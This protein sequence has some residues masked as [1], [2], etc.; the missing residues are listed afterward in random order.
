VSGLPAGYQTQVG[1]RGARLSGGQRQRLGIAR[2]LYR[3][4]EILILDEATSA[5]DHDTEAEVLRAV[6][7]LSGS[8]AVILVAHRLSTLAHCSK[9]YRVEGGC[10]HQTSGE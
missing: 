10:L 1:E 6:K 9:I 7:N 8:R 3:R 4:P 5:L 2:A